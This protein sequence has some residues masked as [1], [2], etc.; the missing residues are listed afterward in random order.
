MP[1]VSRVYEKCPLLKRENI[2]DSR[3]INAFCESSIKNLL[4][5]MDSQDFFNDVRLGDRS[6]CI[7][8]ILLTGR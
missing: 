6:G 5:C 8:F 1:P 7:E 3:I 4:T 2:F